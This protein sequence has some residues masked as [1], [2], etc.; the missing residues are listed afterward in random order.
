MSAGSKKF[1]SR[2]FPLRRR[3]AQNRE[4]SRGLRLDRRPAQRRQ[5]HVAQLARLAKGSP[6]PPDKPQTTR[7]TIQGVV[8]TPGLAQIVFE[9]TP[10][11]HKSD[12]LF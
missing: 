1:A 6:S 3:L 9:D 8:T 5:I 2:G 4:L 11:I 10:G 7:T 12:T